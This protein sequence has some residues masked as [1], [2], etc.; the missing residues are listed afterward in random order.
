MTVP[1]YTD[2]AA[3]RRPRDDGLKRPKPAATRGRQAEARRRVSW[4]VLAE[5]LVSFRPPDSAL[6]DHPSARGGRRAA[7][8]TARR[9]AQGVS[10]GFGVTH[11]PTSHDASSW[12]RDVGT[13]RAE[14]DASTLTEAGV[15]SP[16]AAAASRPRQVAPRSRGLRRLLPGAATLAI[17]ASLWLGAGALSSLNRPVLTVL[18]GAVKVPGGYRYVARPGD[19]LWSIAAR[20]EPGAD[21]RVLVGRLEQQLHGGALIAGDE[22][23][24]P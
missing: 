11:R 13:T 6:S 17:M 12:R 24:L 15:R 8:A 21:P 2:D 18:P 19:T 10:T 7:P 3:R 4:N 14:P 16:V 23:K 5:E 1:A 9:A 20:L 22:L